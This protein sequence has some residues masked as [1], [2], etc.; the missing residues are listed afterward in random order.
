M[1]AV[2][3]E[4]LF[5]ALTAIES[6]AWQ[7]LRSLRAQ[8][9]PLFLALPADR[10]RIPVER[11]VPDYRSLAECNDEPESAD[12]LLRTSAPISQARVGLDLP[13]AGRVTQ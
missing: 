9:Q 6:A 7:H 11:S 5:M 13:L 2:N 8:V 4:R 3:N 1:I 12:Y 10:F